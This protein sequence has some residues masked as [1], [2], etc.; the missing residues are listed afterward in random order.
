MD[1]DSNPNRDELRKRRI[2]PATSSKGCPNIKDLGKLRYVVEQARPS[3]RYEPLGMPSH[4]GDRAAG[5]P[6]FTHGPFTQAIPLLGITN[7]GTV[8]GT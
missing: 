3:S 6:H 8:R 2:L 7:N 1:P 5:V 4:V